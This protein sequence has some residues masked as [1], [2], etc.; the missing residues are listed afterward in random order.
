LT[1]PVESASPYNGLAV[2]KWKTKT[3][4]LIRKH[5]LDPKELAGVALQS[6]E[7]IFQSDIGGF[8]IGKDIFPKPQIIG[9]LLHELISLEIERK[10][11]GKWRRERDTGDKDLVYVADNKYSIEIKTSANPSRIF[12]NRSYA[13]KGKAGKGKKEKAGY[14]LAINFE[15]FNGKHPQIRMIRFGWIDH[16][17]WMGQKAAT[18]QQAHLS[19]DVERNKL[20]ALYTSKKEAVDTNQATL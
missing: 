13:Q 10:H 16:I 19:D 8:R 4:E 9:F 1:E 17:D 12:G 20:L 5:P 15:P 11:G 7:R 3:E 14:Y 2:D 6:W 18:G